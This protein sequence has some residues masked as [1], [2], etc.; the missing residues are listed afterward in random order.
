MSG[1]LSSRGNDIHG[2]SAHAWH[3]DRK[4]RLVALCGLTMLLSAFIVMFSIFMIA[5]VSP[6]KTAVIHVNMFNEAP[7][8][9]I[10]LIS[11][12]VLGIYAFAL[13]FNDFKE[14]RPAAR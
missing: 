8:E 5:Y 10:L 14:M 1:N 12:S 4:R 7:V 2:T 13:L 9:L 3:R 6:S 11:T